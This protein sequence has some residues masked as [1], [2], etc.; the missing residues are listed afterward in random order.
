MLRVTLLS[1]IVA[2][3]LLSGVTQAQMFDITSPGDAIIGVP[4]DNT[5]PGAEPPTAAID[6]DTA[7]KFLHF[8]TSWIPDQATGGAGFRVTPSQSKYV[9]MAL[10]FA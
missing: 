10:N 3:V 2:T 7:T 4:D 9:V 1:V 5:W 6:D 8:K